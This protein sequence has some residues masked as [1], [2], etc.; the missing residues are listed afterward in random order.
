[1]GDFET[2]GTMKV[3]TQGQAGPQPVPVQVPT[4]S[5]VALVRVPDGQVLQ[6]LIYPRSN[7]IRR[8]AFA[9]DGK[10]IFG[11]ALRWTTVSHGGLFKGGWWTT[12]H[13]AWG[14]LLWDTQ[15]GA[16]KLQ[17]PGDTFADGFGP[18]GTL[19]TARANGTATAAGLEIDCW[20]P[21]EVVSEATKAGIA[22]WWQV[23]EPEP[24]P[25]W[26]SFELLAL[27]S[28]AGFGTVLVFLLKLGR[29]LERRRQGLAVTTP[30]APVGGV[31]AFAELA[32]AV[33]C[34]AST[35]AKGPEAWA[36]PEYPFAAAILIF[37]LVNAYMGVATAHVS[38]RWYRRLSSGEG[39]RTGESALVG[40]RHRAMVIEPGGRSQHGIRRVVTTGLWWLLGLVVSFV[41]VACLDRT[42][43]ELAAKLWQTGSSNCAFQ[44]GRVLAVLVVA[45]LLPAVLLY[46]AVTGF[47][48]DIERARQWW[49]GASSSGKS[50][51]PS[52]LERAAVSLASPT[53][54]MRRA[55]WLAVLLVALTVAGFAVHGR[56]AA[57]PWPVLAPTATTAWNAGTTFGDILV[58]AWHLVTTIL[59]AVALFWAIVSALHLAKMAREP[60]TSEPGRQ[61]AVPGAEDKAGEEAATQQTC[62]DQGDSPDLN[63]AVS[64]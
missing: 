61:I 57:G 25:G 34:L 31:V 21:A 5:E 54:G 47:A 26:L 16:L 60:K 8:L 33:F 53:R 24:L 64:L 7:S 22:S 46:I 58:G 59:L 51:R 38:F 37:G 35:A 23:G 30:I 12:T 15:T 27:L 43:L 3:Q 20:R 11:Q 56:L 29:A 9:S 13:E 2:R 36:G 6:R 28:L 42:P 48:S 40:L 39:P 19:A 63:R 44:I 17:L 55:Y 62:V 10:Y 18:N 50:N 41:I 14:I 32:F 49:A 52:A 45:A 4:F 1:E